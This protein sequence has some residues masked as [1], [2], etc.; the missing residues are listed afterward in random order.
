MADGRA[1]EL[2]SAERSRGWLR[3]CWVLALVGALVLA[4]AP[5]TAAAAEV[6]DFAAA[7]A[8]GS[9]FGL[10]DN[11]QM[12][13]SGILVA[14]WTIDPN[15]SNPIDV[16]LYDTGTFLGSF[17][18]DRSRP[19]VAAAYPSAGDRHGFVHLIPIGSDGDRTICAYAINVGAGDPWVTLGCRTFYA[20]HR[21]FGALETV[22]RVPGSSNIRVAGW[23][24]DPDSAASLDIH[25]YVNG[26]FAGARPA[27]TRRDDIGNTW[28]WA[29]PDHGFDVRFDLWEGTHDVCVYAINVGTGFPYTLLGCR[30]IQYTSTPQGALETARVGDNA[31]KVTGWALDQ[32]TTNAVQIQFWID[33]YFAGAVDANQ[34]RAD[35]GDRFPAY[36]PN[37]GFGA[38]LWL[39]PGA[40]QVCAFAINQGAGAPW[41]GLGC[42]GFAPMPPA[43]SGAG[44]RIVYANLS[45]RLWLIG[46]DGFVDNTYAISGKYL[47]PP[48]GVY[49]V[50][51]FQRYAEA[52]HDGIT[53]EYFVAFN[54]AGLGYGFHTI[55]V[56]ADGTPLQSESELGFFRSAGCVRQ[57]R[58]DAIYLWN[59]ANY[60]DPVWVMAV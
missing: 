47:D 28:N 37:R 57:K 50:Y 41:T 48:P 52:G 19:D 36:G 33:G 31:V 8:T 34:Y 10:V 26:Q 32:D 53:M 35:L 54:P 2:D 20:S 21:P 24:I 12:T 45:Q 6:D 30:S 22:E 43:N 56:L 55:P 3:R 51:A 16:H 25:L 40:R 4:A 29:G 14:G 15:T 7:A 5:G 17:R 11:V 27:N 9:P 39:W 60:G 59:W 44:R 18:A 58:S 13:P 23:T 42:S 38:V 49:E 46:S 1:D